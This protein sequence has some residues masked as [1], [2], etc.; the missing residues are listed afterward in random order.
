MIRALS[1]F[2]A[3]LLPLVAS[4]QSIERGP[5]AANVA[6]LVW[7]C[8]PAEGPA[9]KILRVLKD[10]F[11]AYSV[12]ILDQGVV[13]A[14]EIVAEFKDVKRIDAIPGL[15]TLLPFEKYGGVDLVHDRTFILLIN[16]LGNVGQGELKGLDAGQVYSSILRCTAGGNL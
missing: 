10:T 16:K 8:A 14:E 2:A 6:G 3:L 4:A 5:L 15:A 7:Q 12:Q 13:G 11:G 1:V 9:L